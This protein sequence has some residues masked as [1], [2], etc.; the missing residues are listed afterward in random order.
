M[1]L[2]DWQGR[3]LRSL[4][5]G[6]PP[7]SHRRVSSTLSSVVRALKGAAAVVQA[8]QDGFLDG[9]EVGGHERQL[10]GKTNDLGAGPSGILEQRQAC[11]PAIFLK[12]WWA[13]AFSK[14]K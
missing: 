11:R 8:G 5:N 9:T 13:W 3:G 7:P 14:R 2:R 10:P 1:R 12:G 6:G 4:D